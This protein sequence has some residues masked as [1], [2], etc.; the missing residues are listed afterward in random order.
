[1]VPQK[2]MS[3]SATMS[4]TLHHIAKNKKHKTMPTQPGGHFV[5]K[6]A[7]RCPFWCYGLWACVCGV[8]FVCVVGVVGRV[9]LGC[10][11]RC[12]EGGCVPVCAPPVPEMP[13]T[14]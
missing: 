3:T 5:Y 14:T 4:C 11:R 1:M 2:H 13:E 10:G 9:S 6:L 7:I 12:L 8:V